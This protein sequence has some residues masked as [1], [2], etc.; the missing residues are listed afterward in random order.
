MARGT[1]ANT[2]IIN[3]LLEGKVGPNTIHIPTSNFILSI[4]F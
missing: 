3:K 4:N 1:F 2:R